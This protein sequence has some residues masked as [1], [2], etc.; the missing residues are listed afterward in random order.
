M[1]T[2]RH[3]QLRGRFTGGHEDVEAFRAMLLNAVETEEWALTWDEVT[4]FGY[5]GPLLKWTFGFTSR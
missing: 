4:S 5:H 1:S 3:R 2:P